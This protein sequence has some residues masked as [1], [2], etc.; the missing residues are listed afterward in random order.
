MVRTSISSSFSATRLRNWESDAVGRHSGHSGHELGAG[1]LNPVGGYCEHSFEELEEARPKAARELQVHRLPSQ[2]PKPARGKAPDPTPRDS[3]REWHCD[4]ERKSLPRNKRP[5]PMRGTFTNKMGT[6]GRSDVR[7]TQ[8]FGEWAPPAVC[9]V[10]WDPFEN[11]KAEVPTWATHN[12]HGA[13]QEFQRQRLVGDHLKSGTVRSQRRRGDTAPHRRSHSAMDGKTADAGLSVGGGRISADVV[14]RESV[15]LIPAE[16]LVA[17]PS[18]SGVGIQCLVDP[19]GVHTPGRV[20]TRGTLSRR[21]SPLQRPPTSNTLEPISAP[22]GFNFA[23]QT[24]LRPATSAVK[25]KNDRLDDLM[26]QM[27]AENELKIVDLQTRIDATVSR[28]TAPWPWADAD[29]TR[30]AI[31][32]RY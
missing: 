13:R 29:M 12:K 14:E 20:S 25:T 26:E 23:P 5:V 30:T 10:S 9:V 22:P 3:H 18:A 24:P 7:R 11:A 17:T 16:Q 31:G 15:D 19:Q 21:G 6:F 4:S 28:A 1:L 8:G 27:I 2:S 32:P